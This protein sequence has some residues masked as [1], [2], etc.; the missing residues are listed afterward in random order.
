M[1]H[2]TDSRQK[3]LEAVERGVSVAEA[4]RVFDISVSTVHNFRR[5]REERGTLETLKPGSVRHQKIAHDDLDLIHRLIDEDPAITI[6]AIRA[7][8]RV[9]VAESTVW[10]AARKMK[11]ALKKSMIPAE[12][13]HPRTQEQRRNFRDAACSLPGPRQD[14]VSR[15][16]RCQNEDDATLRPFLEV[17][18]SECRNLVAA[19]QPRRLHHN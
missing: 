7:Q 1:A 10:Q 14:G 19:L 4:A 6:N 5:Y 18:T 11:Y 13:H 15:R 16:I 12:Q 3:V 8:L 2:S 9:D 17:T